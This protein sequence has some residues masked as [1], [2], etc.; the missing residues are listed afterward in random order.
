[1]LYLLLG[2]I[3]TLA[4]SDIAFNRFYPSSLCSPYETISAKEGNDWSEKRV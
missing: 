3:L 4:S 1:M 2:M